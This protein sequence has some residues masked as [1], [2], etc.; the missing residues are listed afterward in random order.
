[1]VWRESHT[2][3]QELTGHITD[4]FWI[5]SADM[6]QLHYVSPGFERI[7]GRPTTSLHANPQQWSDFILPADRE[8]VVAAFAALTDHAP[9]LDLEYRIV[10]PGGEIRWVRVRGFQVRDAADKLIRHAGIVTDITDRKVAEAMAAD[11]LRQL[12]DVKAAL[13]EH[14]IVA[15]TDI[16]G[17]ITYVN[18]RFCAISKYSREELLGQDHRVVN[19]GFHPKEFMREL[20]QTISA[21]RVW[22]G[23]VKNRAKDGTFYWVDATIMPFRGADGKPVQYIAIRADITERKRFELELQEANQKLSLAFSQVKQLNA[24]LPMCSYCKKIRDDKDYWQS[25]ETYISQHTDAHFSHGICPDCVKKYI[26]PDIQKL[27]EE[28]DERMTNDE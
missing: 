15:I 2:Q 18:D 7:W 14:A 21:G 19:S 16:T 24:M 8:R 20:W 17:K 12:S 23:E 13:D 3:F 28:E 25:V 26:P 10:R 22:K 27:M 11:A 5:R 9:S 1:M 6:Q 4:V